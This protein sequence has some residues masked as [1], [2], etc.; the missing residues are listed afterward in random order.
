MN[1]TVLR[2]LVTLTVAAF[3]S[4][5]SLVAAP[6]AFGTNTV[7]GGPTLTIGAAKTLTAVTQQLNGSYNITY[8]VV[9]HNYGST[10]LYNVQVTDNLVGTFPNPATFSIVGVPS[11]S[12]TLAANASFN[13]NGNTDLLSAGSTLAA[14]GEET[15]SFTVNVT[16]PGPGLYYN[17]AVATGTDISNT[18]SVSDSSD[19][20]TNPDPNGNNNPDEA[21]ENDPTPTPLNANSVTTVGIAKTIIDT[22][23][24]NC[25]YQIRYQ[26]VVRNL[27]NETLDNVQ[28]TDVLDNVFP[29]PATFTVSNVS[30]GGPAA[31]TSTLGLPGYD[32]IGNSV[33][34]FLD[35][36]NTSI[37]VGQDLYIFFTATVDLQGTGGVFG[38]NATVT[39]QGQFTNQATT[40]I[41]DWGTNPDPDG[42]GNP[43][44]PIQ[45]E[46]DPTEFNVQTLDLGLAK[47]VVATLQPDGSYN[48]TYSVTIQNYGDNTINNIT[49]TDNLSNTFP[50]PV[51]FE[52]I[53]FPSVSQGTL[54]P[55]ITFGE[56]N[57]WELLEANSYLSGNTTGVI[58]FTLNVL[59]NN[60]TDTLFFNSAIGF[61]SG[62][63]GQ[64]AVDTSMNGTN[65]DPN[66]NS[67]ATDPG[68]AEPTPIVL[69]PTITII[70]GGFSPN[71]DGVNDFFVITNIGGKKVTME[72][73]NRWGAVVYKNDNYD[74]TWDGN[75]NTGLAIGDNLP[76]GTYWYVI[77]IDDTKEVKEYANYITLSR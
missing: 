59:L 25:Q 51:T 31:G 70:P 15:V 14:G 57:D 77:K 62:I 30:L 41:S 2:A 66:F 63:C 13:G 43:N 55:N 29:L 34:T 19:W 38:N 6:K 69:V 32:G 75:S 10:T 45:F 21:T 71:A 18:I 27:G 56:N 39:A 7:L 50:A 40:D 53:A 5:Q 67:S 16:V 9:V 23:L 73:F 12:G 4:V 58:T 36:A 26:I 28:V 61:A 64:T 48:V 74:N 46:N 68:E 60:T 33:P 22:A 76:T 47:S 17:T 11:A 65:P 3:M 20:G 37:G 52:V 24:V 44:E 54:V 1:K 42:D 8:L 49:V 35:A 72:I